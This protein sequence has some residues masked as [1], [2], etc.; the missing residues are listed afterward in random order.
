MTITNKLRLSFAIFIGS[1]LV[2]AIVGVKAISA[3][4]EHQQ[5][6]Q[7]ISD[8]SYTQ[9][10]MASAVSS[11]ISIQ[12]LAALERL[13]LHTFDIQRQFSEQIIPLHRLKDH[14]FKDYAKTVI[15]DESKLDALSKQLFK[16]RRAFLS[17][18]VELQQILAKHHYAPPEFI[19]LI[20][21]A[22]DKSIVQSLVQINNSSSYALYNGMKEADV[23]HWL[24]AV[25]TLKQ[26]LLHNPKLKTHLADINEKMAER[27]AFIISM[28]E[29]SRRH[30]RY[31]EEE[32]QLEQLFAQT[33]EENI[34]HGQH[35][36][37]QL[38]ANIEATAE[39]T[40]IIKGVVI[41][42]MLF[43]GVLIS[44]Y[45]TRSITNSIAKM[46]WAVEQVGTGDLDYVMEEQGKN[47]FTVLAGA[48]NHMTSEMKQN[49]LEMSQYNQR[50]EQKISERT[51]ELKDA[52]DKVEKNN[53]ALEKLSAQLSKY[54]SPQL[55][56][57][58]FSG[59][60][61]VRLETSRK[62][63]TVFF[64]D[65]QGFTQ[66]TD[67]MDPEA[68]TM[69][70]NVYLTAMTQIA[71]E[72]GGTIDKFIGDAVM[73]FFG[74]PESKGTHEDAQA[75]VNM[76]LAM[77][78]KMGELKA[79]WQDQ[80]YKLPFHIRM[81]INT[82]YCTVGN[83]GAEDRMDYTIIGGNV[84]LASRL[85]SHAK[86]DQILISHTTQQL[87]ADKV[88]SNP[89]EEIMVKGIATPIQT[90]EVLRHSDKHIDATHIHRKQLGL[91]IDL[92][93]NKIDKREAVQQLK[94][95]IDTLDRSEG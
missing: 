28:V 66:L 57:S 78:D 13:E 26:K 9:M 16:T 65:I 47:E 55:F 3:I 91:D 6:M 33:V 72:H 8:L 36:K 24:E 81:G 61:E 14:L 73:V 70:L 37:R 94:E 67:T 40:V 30:N 92:D 77:K 22:D 89:L 48:F 85:E 54:L 41:I 25:A 18:T 32:D 56:Q 63:L 34:R 29:T 50:L 38:V 20:N 42:F 84:N 53:K 75:C 7:E 1:L 27:R 74:D 12:N 31:G 49:K 95:V 10:K 76:A 44:I 71:I 86:P 83:F 82:G 52:I 79:Y 43:I 23:N 59:K 80:G 64:S 15:E 62:K 5:I 21:I 45:L 46:K 90:H 4:R 11:V 68:M 51:V 60:Q 39:Q 69:V 87:V 17:S 19:E 58:I 2:P 35:A 93:L 88:V